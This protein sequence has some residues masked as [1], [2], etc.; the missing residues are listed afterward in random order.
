[1][2]QWKSVLVGLAAVALFGGAVTPAVAQQSQFPPR[3]RELNESFADPDAMSRWI[4]VFEREGR[5]FYDNRYAILDLMGLKPGSNVADIG[6]G[7]GLFSR[8]FA[9]RVGPSGTVYA[10]DIA[11]SLVDHIAETARA[12]ELDNIVPVLGDPRSPK[13]AENSVDVVFVAAAYHHF[14]YNEEMLAE[15][16]KALRPDGLLLLLDPERI[17]GK[18]SRGTLSMVRAGKGTVTDEVIDAGFEL[19]EEVDM[20]EDYYVLKF[21][22]REMSQPSS[23]RR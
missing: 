1:M 8:L 15:I 23:Q 11:Q 13:L 14:E 12:M 21:K 22:H 7:S 3:A 18:S 2:M 6:A 20:F 17:E 16:K 4:D 10:V 9:Q 19:I 5:D